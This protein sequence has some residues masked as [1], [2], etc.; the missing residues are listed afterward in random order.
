MD[1][2]LAKKNPEQKLESFYAEWDKL[3]EEIERSRSQTQ[4]K[5]IKKDQT[6]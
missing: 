5:L 1:L 2:A 6:F 3:Q 4:Y